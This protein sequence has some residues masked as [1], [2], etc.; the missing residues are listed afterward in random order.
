MTEETQKNEQQPIT[1][2]IENLGE[3]SNEAKE[4][5]TQ[6][7]EE[8]KE[9]FGTMFEQASKDVNNLGPLGRLFISIIVIIAL[10][11]LTPILDLLYYM[12][13]IVVLP[14]LFLVALGIFSHETYEMSMGWIEQVILH[15]RKK[16]ES[17]KAK[18]N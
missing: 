12:I 16:R 15:F 7:T 6:A 5:L 11:K 2:K 17:E 14:M 8:V 4:N 13:Q 1:E 9:N 10:L 3:Q 18:E